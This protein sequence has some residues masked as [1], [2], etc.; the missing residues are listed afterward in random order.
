MQQL[1]VLPALITETH[2]SKKW[3]E[4]REKQDARRRRESSFLPLRLSLVSSVSHYSRYA[5]C[6]SH[7]R[8]MHVT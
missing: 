3:E 4:D 6:A 1:C 2:K 5:R 8:L 7:V